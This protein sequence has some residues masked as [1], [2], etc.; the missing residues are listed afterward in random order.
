M[1]TCHRGTDMT[2]V[3]QVAAVVAHD[4]DDVTNESELNMSDAENQEDDAVV[5]QDQET[6]HIDDADGEASNKTNK[7][8]KENT[9]DDKKKRS[10]A[11]NGVAKNTETKEDAK[12]D[13]DEDHNISDVALKKEVSE[14]FRIK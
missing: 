5:D 14:E 3:A 9:A 10:E 8:H 2:E 12:D 11:V 7:T 13:A 4:M 1:S 6:S